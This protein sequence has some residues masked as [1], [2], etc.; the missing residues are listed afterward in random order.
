MFVMLSELPEYNDKIIVGH[1]MTP[2][3][4]LKY[5][6]PLV[7]NFNMHAVNTVAVSSKIAFVDDTF[8]RNNKICSFL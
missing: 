7:E 3:V 4:I 1:A 8:E 5:N 6:H 2:T